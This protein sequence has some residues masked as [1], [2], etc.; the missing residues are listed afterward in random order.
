MKKKLEETYM[1]DREGRK[2][3]VMV[4]LSGG[5]HSFVT[6]YLLKIQKYDL[7]ALTVVVGEMD[8]DNSALSCQITSER[9]DVIRSFCKSLGIAHHIANAEDEFKERV[10]DP[11]LSEKITGGLGVPC[12]NCHDLRMQVLFSKAKEY[13]IDQVATGHFGKIFKN[14][15]HHSV[16]VH[17]GNDE[18]KDQSALLSRLGPEILNSLLLPL[19]DLQEK[20]VLKLAE[21]FGVSFENSSPNVF[22]CLESGDQITELIEKQVPARFLT[23]G[24]V[25]KENDKIGDHPGIHHATLGGAVPIIDMNN[26]NNS[27]LLGKYVVAEKKIQVVTEEYF[28]VNQFQLLKCSIANETPWSEPFRGVVRKT[29]NDAQDCW[30]YPKSLHSAFIVLDG[31]LKLVEGEIVSINKRKGKNSKVFLSGV[32]KYYAE[33]KTEEDSD[34]AKYKIDPRI[35]F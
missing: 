12:W 14:E 2:S 8:K 30:V 27:L 13:G 22:H 31:P 34:S 1:P 18:L 21:N 33:K 16:F 3:R 15:N 26:Q 9:L 24:E 5:I 32:V 19:S 35:D 25:F 7:V 6:A 28:N 20:E 11:W 23:K 4:G 10:L 29:N 17:T